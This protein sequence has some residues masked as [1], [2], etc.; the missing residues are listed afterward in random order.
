MSIDSS[1]L[2]IDFGALCVLAP[3]RKSCFLR[4]ALAL[5]A[6]VLVAHPF[7]ALAQVVVAPSQVTPQ[8]LRPAPTNEP[9]GPAVSGPEALQAPAGANRVNVVVRRL[10][11]EGG[12]PELER[13]TR[14]LA[15]PIEGHPVTVARIYEF[16]NALEQAYAR[17]GYVLARV[18]LPPQ[19]LI[20]RGDVRIIIVDGFIEKVQ[21]D[22]VAERV[23][24]L[25]ASRT[26]SLVGRRH[27]TLAEIERS[28]L[29]A[30]DA[31]G[32]RLKS[33]LARGVS[34]GGAL[35]VLEG[36][37][38]LVTGTVGVDDLLPASLGT[39]SYGGDVALN[40]PFGFGEQFYASA[41]AGGDPGLIFNDTSP[42]W[43]LGAGI[44][45]PLGLEGWTVNPEYTN[46]RTQPTPGMGVLAN[47]GRFQRLA[48]RTSYPLIRT[49]SQVLTLTGAFEYIVQN[50]T[51]PLLATDLSEDRYGAVRVGATSDSGLPW[52]NETLQA[53]AV[54][55]HGTGGRDGADASGVPLSQEGAGPLFAKANVDARLIQPLPQSFQ[56]DLIGRGQDSFG[57]PLLV[58]EQLQLDGPLAVSG[59]P[60]GT[61]N[62]DEGA[63]LRG[64]LSRSLL[65]QGDGVP[66]DLTPY[67]FGA[68]GIGRLLEPT[69]LEVGVQRAASFGVGLRSNIDMPNG[70]QGASLGLEVARQ[71]SDLKTVA[72]GWR[73]N[74]T[75]NV[76]F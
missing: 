35:L 30:G 62:V 51:V 6:V 25:V 38:Q 59:Y 16:A 42:F 1:K 21:V 45:A 44:V 5:A 2:I 31:P 32:L 58:P 52:L 49:R 74:V 13:E 46:S 27:I 60:I 57:K 17:A 33:T 66:I 11:I 50:V 71:Y 20:D 48:L 63:S 29:I 9:S 36:T 68:F 65:V 15:Q 67:I 22:N 72:H 76:R 18:T 64:E 55:S 73:G 23:R 3:I 28:L 26:A 54:F 53:S 19:K 4:F 43:L 56:F 40:S 10:A 8:T 14:A 69:V 34:P 61:L 37:H 39:W 24:E 70:Y 47:V 41:R 7:A 12:F 75:L